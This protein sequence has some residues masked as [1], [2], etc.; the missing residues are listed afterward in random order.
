MAKRAYGQEAGR[1]FARTEADY[2]DLERMR[3]AYDSRHAFGNINA[4]AIAE[5]INGDV[6]SIFG[7]EGSPQSS[8]FY[9][10]FVEGCLEILE[11]LGPDDSDDEDDSD[12]KLIPS[13]DV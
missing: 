11:S 2:V 13:G 12:I 7:E 8:A 10:G 5:V 1:E 4:H 6:E 3:D 9:R